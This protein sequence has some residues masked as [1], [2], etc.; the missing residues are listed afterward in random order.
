MK[1]NAT[2]R[3]KRKIRAQYTAAA[4]RLNGHN[5]SVQVKR[6]LLVALGYPAED[7]DRIPS[8]TIEHTFA[9][10][11]PLLTTPIRPHDTI[12]DLG[13]GAGLDCILLANRLNGQNRVVGLDITPAMV[14]RARR[15]AAA[16]GKLHIQ[17]GVGDAEAL[18]LG[19]ATANV[20]L[21]N[22]AICL[23]GDK[24]KAF[25]EVFRVLR[26]GGRLAVTDLLHTG[27][28]FIRQL[29]YRLCG[30]MTV[31]S[32]ADYQAMVAAA[33]F[34]D[35]IIHCRR[36][37]RIDEAASLWGVRPFIR[38]LARLGSRRVFRPVANRLLRGMS[39]IHLTAVKPPVGEKTLST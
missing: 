7:L 34:E 37:V 33:G 22:G 4:E 27:P 35:V 8:A 17:F 39:T 30:A 20:V 24:E 9:C 38:F 2:A 3:T 13:S 28:R 5:N 14:S 15:Y 36:V 25:R 26:G 12:V 32:P 29:T 18:P 31:A 23:V 1:P 10:G 19:D 16:A 21:S 11:N 6:R